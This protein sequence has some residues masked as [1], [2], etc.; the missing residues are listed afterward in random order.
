MVVVVVDDMVMMSGGRSV[1]VEVRS[2][3]RHTMRMRMA[4]RRRSVLLMLLH[5]MLAFTIA[6]PLEVNVHQLLLLNPLPTLHLPRFLAMSLLAL[7][8]P[9]PLLLP[10]L[11]LPQ[12]LPL[13]LT[14]MPIP[15]P[16]P[17]LPLHLRPLIHRMPPVPLLLG[18]GH[19]R[20]HPHPRAQPSPGRR[21]V[22]P[23]FV[24]VGR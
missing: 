2:A 21:R 12:L 10:T 19:V 16:L 14:Q 18:T 6:M 23:M 3:R 24:S 13:P 22:I 20:R 4:R 17:L 5:I 11:H 15:L 8:I 7:L 9:T 1:E